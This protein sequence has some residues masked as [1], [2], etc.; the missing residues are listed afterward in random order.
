MI[1]GKL[2]RFI[3][4]DP[5][6]ILPFPLINN[7]IRDRTDPTDRSPTLLYLDRGKFEYTEILYSLNIFLMQQSNAKLIIIFKTLHFIFV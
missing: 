1:I 3:K 2:G 6:P 4:T 5:N 7:F